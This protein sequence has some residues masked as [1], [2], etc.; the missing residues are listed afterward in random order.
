MIGS[1]ITIVLG[2]IMYLYLAYWKT[3]YDGYSGGGMSG[4]P[5]AFMMLLALLLMGL[6]AI[7]FLVTLV[8]FF[9]KS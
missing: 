5:A 2:L 4:L 8:M 7:V 3:P 6:G 1:S 9:L